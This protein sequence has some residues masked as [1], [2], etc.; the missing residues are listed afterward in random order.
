MARVLRGHPKSQVHHFDEDLERLLYPADLISDII[1]DARQKTALMAKISKFTQVVG[2]NETHAKKILIEDVENA[3]RNLYDF[4]YLADTAL[5]DTRLIESDIPNK[6][7]THLDKG[8]VVNKVIC[9]AINKLRPGTSIPHDPPPR[10]WYPYLILKN[11]YLDGL[12]NRDIMMRLYIS[13]GTFNRTRRNAIRGLARTLV[14]ME[15]S[16]Q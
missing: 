5:A 7:A 14:E 10:E 13:E 1:F 16:I 15:T 12:P 6:N 2:V 9:D 8:K 4:I 11:A 3:L